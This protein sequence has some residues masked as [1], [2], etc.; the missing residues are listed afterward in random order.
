MEPLH[1]RL[2]SKLIICCQFQLNYLPFKKKKIVLIIL[3]CFKKISKN[4]IMLFVLWTWIWNVIKVKK[5]FLKS[6]YGHLFQHV[7]FRPTSLGSRAFYKIKLTFYHFNLNEYFSH[8]LDFLKFNFD[9]WNIKT[10][11]FL[12]ERFFKV[13]PTAHGRI[14]T[15]NKV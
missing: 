1:Q 6:S 15:T 12:R 2:F 3:E 13:A 7:L 4:C 11:T 5:L 9:M 14:W 10:Y 8:I